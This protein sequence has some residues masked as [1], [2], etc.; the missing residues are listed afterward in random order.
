M[1]DTVK[2]RSRV[3]DR[4]IQIVLDLPER[5]GE[6]RSGK[7]RF[8]AGSTTGRRAQ[9]LGMIDDDELVLVMKSFS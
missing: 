8:S 4:L 7:T 6:C 1:Y 3:L 5:C 2:V 9:K